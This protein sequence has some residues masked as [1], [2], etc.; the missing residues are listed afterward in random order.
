M[1]IRPL[2]FLC[3]TLALAGTARAG[4]LTLR[5]TGLKAEGTVFVAL[6][7]GEKGFKGNRPVATAKARPARGG[8]VAAFRSV[9]AGD[10]AVKAFQD[11]D[12]D[13]RLSVN[14]LGIPKEPYAFSN[15]ARGRFGQPAW[16]RAAFA[17]GAKGAA[18]TIR[19]D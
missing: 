18:Q 2:A 12:G 1:P 13:G 19:L 6:F 14:A 15:N 17:L 16:A 3:L 9:A 4:T 8:A 11:E 5:F 7:D 10:Y